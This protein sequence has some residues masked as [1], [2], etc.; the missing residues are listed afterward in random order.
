MIRLKNKIKNP[1]PKFFGKGILV[2]N[3]YFSEIPPT[4]PPM[5]LNANPNPKNLPRKDLLVVLL[6]NLGIYIDLLNPRYVAGVN[7][8]SLLLDF[9][10]MPKE[11][12]IDL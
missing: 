11:L 10:D 6:L 3:K 7:L 2:L 5:L 12:M 8:R 1:Y 9:V 4:N